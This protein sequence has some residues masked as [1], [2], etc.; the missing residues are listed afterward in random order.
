VSCRNG[1]GTRH[2]VPAWCHTWYQL[3]DRT[4]DSGT[5][6]TSLCILCQ[7]TPTCLWEVQHY[8]FGHPRRLKERH[9]LA[10]CFARPLLDA[11]CALE[12]HTIVTAARNPCKMSLRA[13]CL[14]NTNGCQK[15]EKDE[16]VLSESNISRPHPRPAGCI[17]IRDMPAQQTN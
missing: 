6:L 11:L 13:L 1:S 3:P 4:E 7:E 15:A 14:L 12:H 9:P 2:Q 5:L 16:G 17:R 10:L 8:K